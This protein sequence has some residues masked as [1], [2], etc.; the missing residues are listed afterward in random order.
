MLC[1]QFSANLRP[2]ACIE[3]SLAD[4]ALL[5]NMPEFAEQLRSGNIKL[6]AYESLARA[7]LRLDVLTILYQRILDVAHCVVRFLLIDASPQIGRNFLL[8]R[9]DS[10]FLPVEARD[11][12]DLLCQLDVSDN[13]RTI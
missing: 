12:P 1:L 10:F 6:P 9:E 7:K 5:F 3:D 13:F 11:N 4:A 2:G 8:V